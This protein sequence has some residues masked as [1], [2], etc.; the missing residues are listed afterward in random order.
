M[1]YPTN[2]PELGAL[3]D[4]IM[5]EYDAV[6][7]DP[8][9]GFHF[10]T[11]RFLARRVG[12]ETDWLD[13]IPEAAIESFAGTGNPFS[14]DPLRPGEAVVDIG[15]GAGIDTLIAANMVGPDGFV[16]GVDMTQSM[17]D[18]A[19]GAAAD[20]GFENV[21]FRKGYGED[22]PVESGW[23]DVVISNGVLNLM[24]DKGLALME[25]SRVLGPNGR[26]QIGDIL[27]SKEVPENAKERIDL[28]TG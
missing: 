14:L 11:G 19:S 12:Y 17:L 22:L 28:W 7:C 16:V 6:A 21:E 13:G 1:T 10:H 5:E 3:R 9:R 26:L 20:G 25:M 18:K 15:S 24:P 23:A 4:A 8:G 2:A 27:V